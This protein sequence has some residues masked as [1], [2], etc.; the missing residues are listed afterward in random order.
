MRPRYPRGAGR[1][2][3]L[4]ALGAS[5]TLL[6]QTLNLTP[7]SYE[8]RA[9]SDFPAQAAAAMSPE[10]LARAR[11]P[12]MRTACIGD[13]DLSQ[14]RDADLAQ[15]RQLTGQPNDPTCRLA[16]QSSGGNRM[17]FVLQ[18]AHS[19]IRFDGLLAVNSFRATVLVKSDQGQTTTV[20]LSGQR[21]GNCTK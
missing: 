14:G 21:I 17:R 16:Q 8:L 7:G 18:C 4:A 13:S 1:A 2:A 9:T 20:N 5:A 12:Q 19:T 15:A 6:A 11:E 10:M 3:A